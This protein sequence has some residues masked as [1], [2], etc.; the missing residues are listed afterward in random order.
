M[1]KV[2]IGDSVFTFIRKDRYPVDK[3]IVE[4]I[5]ETKEK[6]IIVLKPTLDPEYHSKEETIEV[7][8][9]EVFLDVEQFKKYLISCRDNDILEYTKKVNTIYEQFTK[10][11]K[12]N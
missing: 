10:N 9:N 8:I 6:T 5:I 11:Y 7:E 3:R 12:L 1:E 2:K 4:K